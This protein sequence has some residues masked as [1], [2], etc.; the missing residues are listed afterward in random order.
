MDFSLNELEVA[1]GPQVEMSLPGTWREGS[2]RWKQEQDGAIVSQ[3]EGSRCGPSLGSA[4][5]KLGYTGGK[6]EGS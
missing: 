1:L 5:R 6:H 2:G 4:L 3:P